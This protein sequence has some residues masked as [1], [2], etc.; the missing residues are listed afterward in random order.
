MNMFQV[1]NTV[2]E[3]V[4]E[5]AQPTYG[6]AGGAGGA[7]GGYGAAKAPA[8]RQVSLPFLHSYAVRKAEYHL[9][10]YEG[11]CCKGYGA[12]KAPTLKIELPSPFL[13]KVRRLPQHLQGWC[14]IFYPPTQDS[15]RCLP[16][17]VG[18]SKDTFRAA[19]FSPPAL[20]GLRHSSQYQTARSKK[21][22]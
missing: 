18:D 7:S 3:E 6:G 4:C 17:E 15:F 2:Y 13:Q 10:I 14:E 1:C 8:C 5:A 16:L 11:R 21:L 19:T 12:S 9:S 20:R 22:L